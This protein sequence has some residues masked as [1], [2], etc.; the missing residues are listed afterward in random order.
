MLFK[1][2]DRVRYRNILG[3]VR[4]VAHWMSPASIDVRLDNGSLVYDLEIHFQKVEDSK[5]KEKD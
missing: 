4:S 2:G 3:T 5:D 1:R